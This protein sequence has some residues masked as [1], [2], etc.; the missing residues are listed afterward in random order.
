LIGNTCALVEQRYDWQQI[1]QKFVALVE[2]TVQ[3][4]LTQRE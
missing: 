1:G 4:R 2:E 3:I